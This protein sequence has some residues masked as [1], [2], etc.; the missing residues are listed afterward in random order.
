MKNISKGRIAAA[1]FCIIIFITLAK[2]FEV[3][4]VAL[5][6]KLALMQFENNNISY[7]IYRFMANSEDTIQLIIVAIGLIICILIL[8]DNLFSTKR[9]K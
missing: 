5:K 4:S 8:R 7:G 9:N 6:N 2:F 1:S 3:Y